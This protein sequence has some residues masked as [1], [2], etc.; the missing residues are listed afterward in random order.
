MGDLLM[1]TLLL[2]FGGVMTFLFA[3]IK[4]KNNEKNE[5]TKRAFEATK[6]AM[7]VQKDI[8][9]MP[10]DAKRE[11]MRKKFSRSGE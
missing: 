1:K 3:F 8:D 11:L 9:A 2:L 7:G 10:S 6:E 5:Q 4:G